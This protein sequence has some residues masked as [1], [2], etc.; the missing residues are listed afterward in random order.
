MNGMNCVLGTVLQ[1]VCVNMWLHISI[2]V[3]V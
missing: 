3:L 1:Y 2:D